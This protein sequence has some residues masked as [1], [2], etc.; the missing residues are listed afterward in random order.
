MPVNGL[1]RTDHLLKP[2]T[3]GSRARGRGGG[4][5]CLGIAVLVLMTAEKLNL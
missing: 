5:S 3:V 4:A 2:H 1:R